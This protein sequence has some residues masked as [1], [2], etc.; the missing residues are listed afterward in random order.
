[1]VARGNV[2]L[3]EREKSAR[4][5]EAGGEEKRKKN[6]RRERKKAR[7]SRRGNTRRKGE[8]E[9]GADLEGTRRGVGIGAG[10]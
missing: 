7:R 5:E 1:M 6:R 8:I 9:G 4:K 3:T 10:V 2:G